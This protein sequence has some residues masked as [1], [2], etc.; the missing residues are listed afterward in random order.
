[1]SKTTD[2]VI[3]ELQRIRPHTYSD[4]DVAGWISRLDGDVSLYLKTD[5]APISYSWPTDRDKELF[6]P[7]PYDD[8]YVLYCI[9]QVDYFN[10]EYG[11]YANSYAMYNARLQDFLKYKTRTSS[12][13]G[14]NSGTSGTLTGTSE[15]HIIV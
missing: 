15:N 11:Q 7:F 14:T 2:T 3:S 10:R 8:V 12:V 1:M 5:G 13:S 9:A 4:E 6:I